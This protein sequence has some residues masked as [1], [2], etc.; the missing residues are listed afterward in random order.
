MLL[1][2][3]FFFF[4]KSW[5]ARPLFDVFLA[6]RKRTGIHFH[7]L[8]YSCLHVVGAETVDGGG[9]GG[10]S[11]STKMPEVSSV[12]DGSRDGDFLSAPGEQGHVNA[13]LQV[14]AYAGLPLE[15]KKKIRK[16]DD[17]GGASESIFFSLLAPRGYI[18]QCKTVCP[19]PRV[20]G[21][22]KAR[23]QEDASH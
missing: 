12:M 13:A 2:L 19:T 22:K 10:K 8:I 20:E 17:V 11:I 1:S 5:L 3:F 18:R 16:V 9:G 7:G 15:K 6:A 14:S 23:E 21:K 4:L